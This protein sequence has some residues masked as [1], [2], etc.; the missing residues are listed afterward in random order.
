MN[1]DPRLFP[2]QTE[3]IVQEAM[4][5]SDEHISM[6]LTHLYQKA[7]K[8][9]KHFNGSSVIKKYTVEKN[10][11]LF[12]KGRLIDGMNFMKTGKEENN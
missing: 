10:Q 4:S 5:L 7:S 9:V 6:A 1:S 3:D 12:S 11:I 2:I 8:E